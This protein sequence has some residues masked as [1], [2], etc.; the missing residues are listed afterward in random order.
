[1]NTSKKIVATMLVRLDSWSLEFAL[2]TALEWCD[3]IVVGI[4]EPG[5]EVVDPCWNV[6]A[7]LTGDSDVARR[8]DVVAMPDATWS[9]MSMRQRLLERAREL[10]GTHIAIID[11]DEGLT[12]NIIDGARSLVLGLA[13]GEAIDL[14][15]V[16]P[17]HGASNSGSSLDHARTDGVFGRARITLAFCDRPGICWADAADGY[18]YH[19]RTPRN[20]E[21]VKSPPTTDLSGVFHIQ[22]AELARLGAKAAYYKIIEREKF[23]DRDGS[24]AS[25]LNKKYDWTLLDDGETYEKIPDDRWAYRYGDGRSFVCLNEVPW[26]AYAVCVLVGRHADDGLLDGVNLNEWSWSMVKDVPHPSY[27]RQF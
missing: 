24:S 21:S 4:H 17:H 23:P 10:G 19:A 9:E 7:K 1:M 15:M 2:R 16:S 26:Q 22:Y 14:P 8:I 20:V 25:E 3:E 5:G 13:P 11:A 12:A 18:C 27:V 6:I